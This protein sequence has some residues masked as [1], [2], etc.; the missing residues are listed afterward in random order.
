MNLKLAAVLIALSLPLAGCGNKGPLV[1][2]P[3]PAEPML[4]AP[5]DATDEND[6]EGAP[7]SETPTVDDPAAPPPPPSAEPPVD[8][9]VDVDDDPTI[10]V[11]VETSP[12]P[13]AN[14]D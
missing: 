8:V 1:L 5:A 4:D 3:P 2:P 6:V 14:D 11:P 7:A 13:P 12:T 10:E 9:D